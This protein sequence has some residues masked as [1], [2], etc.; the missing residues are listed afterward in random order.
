[1]ADARSR[2]RDLKALLCLS[3][4]LVFRLG[5]VLMLTHQAQIVGAGYADHHA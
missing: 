1:M 5:S 2:G 3:N 4:L